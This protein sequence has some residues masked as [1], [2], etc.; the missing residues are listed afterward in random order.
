[1]EKIEKL[2][3]QILKSQEKMEK[4]MFD[5]KGEI[6]GMKGEISGIKGEISGMKGEISG[7]KS[8][9]SGMKGEIAD[10]KSE[11]S[12]M[13]G[14]ITKLGI[15]Q[16]KMQKDIKLLAEGH[17]NIIETMDRR[18]NEIGE[19]FNGRLDEV[20]AAITN[21]STDVKFVEQKELQN[22]KSIFRLKEDLKKAK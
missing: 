14:E 12:D 20:E 22:E 21:L 1:M 13:K 11:M 6:S 5:M 18:F 9:M 17:E 19:E 8:E 16:E 3:G 2:L 15:L 10:I 7:I 4:D